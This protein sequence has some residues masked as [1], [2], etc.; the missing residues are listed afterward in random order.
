MVLRHTVGFSPTLH[1]KQ[2]H[3]YMPSVQQVQERYAFCVDLKEVL[4]FGLANASRVFSHA[5][6]I[7]A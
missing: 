6:P 2:C 4:L 5:Q 3:Y 7:E 1:V